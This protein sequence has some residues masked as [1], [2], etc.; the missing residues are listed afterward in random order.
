MSRWR[1][2]WTAP[3]TTSSVWCWARP[4]RA[5]REAPD[6]GLRRSALTAGTG[7]GRRADVAAGPRGRTRVRVQLAA[8]LLDRG[9][10]RDR[11]RGAGTP[12]AGGGGR[13]SRRTRFGGG[14]ARLACSAAGPLLPLSRGGLRV[15]SGAA[16]APGR[17]EGG[18]AGCAAGC[19]WRKR[20]AR[21]AGGGGERGGAVGEGARPGASPA[22]V[23]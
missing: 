21:P 18:G 2:W 12:H 19:R 11:R 22:L 13:R 20:R 5:R 17:A 3:V 1:R 6:G 10:G 7:P 15:A 14:P 8:S 4:R 23:Y 16:G 9:A